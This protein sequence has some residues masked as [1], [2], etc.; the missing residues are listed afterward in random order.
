MTRFHYT[1]L[2][3]ILTFLFAFYFYNS[4]RKPHI[5]IIIADDV[6]FKRKMKKISEHIL[7]RFDFL[8]M[9]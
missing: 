5:I 6:V 2:L 7:R 4:P 9:E 8:G 3:T 1:S